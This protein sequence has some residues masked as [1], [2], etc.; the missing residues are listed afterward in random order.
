MAK[1]PQREQFLSI[2]FNLIPGFGTKSTELNRLC[3]HMVHHSEE[4]HVYLWMQTVLPI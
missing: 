1:A 3:V 4:P 2:V